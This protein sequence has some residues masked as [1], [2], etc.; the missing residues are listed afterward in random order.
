M[1]KLA[2]KVQRL[3]QRAAEIRQAIESVPPKISEIRETVATTTGQ[4]QKLRSDIV[5][6]VATLRAETDPQLLATLGEVD[7]M[8]D[9]LAEAGCRLKGVEMDLGP[10]RRLVVR[11]ERSEDVGIA[12]LRALLAANAHRAVTKAVLSALIQADELASNVELSQLHYATL[13]IEVGLI[14]S[15][16]IGWQPKRPEPAAPPADVVGSPVSAATTPQA[17]A[18]ASPAFQQSSFFERRPAQPVVAAAVVAAD[19]VD[20][21]EVASTPAPVAASAPA[22]SD[23]WKRTALDRFKK[24]PDLNKRAR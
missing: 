3:S 22:A 16:R 9:V 7:G 10:S 1:K 14:P 18:A 20:T 8:G 15:V 19:P 2:S 6:S 17:A 11:L 23:D 21:K 4:L 5:S 12:R 13:T 24:M